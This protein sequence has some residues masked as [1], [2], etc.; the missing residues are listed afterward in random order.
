MTIGIRSAPFGSQIATGTN[1]WWD[2]LRVEPNVRST[3]A[4]VPTFGRVQR[5]V[6][7][8][9][10]GVYAYQFDNAVA[11]QEKEVY[12]SVQ[13]PHGKLL[14]SAIDLHIHWV[15]VTAGTA[16]HKV[17]WG[18]E[19][20][21]ANIGGAFPATTTIY[22]DTP[23]L[24]SIDVAMSHCLTA[25]AAEA[26]PA[27]ETLSS[28]MLCRVFRDSANAADTATITAG[29]LFIDAHIEMDRIGSRDE[30]TQ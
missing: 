3:G 9:S 15:P 14:G 23:T 13:M 4:Q 27:S 18:L 11:G 16:G 24:G 5:D 17:R 12:F 10:N 7:G 25:F 6:G 19:Y 1:T 2:D 29:M 30:Y 28:V 26:A 20:T 8:T 22:A 21:W